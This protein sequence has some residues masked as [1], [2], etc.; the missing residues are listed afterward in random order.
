[1]SLKIGERRMRPE[2]ARV[3]G[4]E[5]VAAVILGIWIP[6]LAPGDCTF[7]MQSR[8]GVEPETGKMGDEVAYRPGKTGDARAC[9]DVDNATGVE[10][11]QRQQTGEACGVGHCL[12]LSGVMFRNGQGPEHDG[13]A[14]MGGRE[15][16]QVDCRE[17]SMA[18]ERKRKRG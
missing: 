9:V 2:S 10:A 8:R 17:S 11:R 3:D 15:E 7:C 4:Q 5:R 12:S 14:S 18:R 6:D 13:W 16:G 1:M